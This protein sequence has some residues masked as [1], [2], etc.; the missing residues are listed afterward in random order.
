MSFVN[1]ISLVDP[2]RATFRA[3]VRSIAPL[4]RHFVRRRM[5]STPLE[6]FCASWLAQ[7]GCSGALGV[8]SGRQN[9][10]FPLFFVTL[11]RLFTISLEVDKTL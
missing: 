6:R 11:T 10:V 3:W 9:R 1:A 4:V 5:R 8:D 2:P 7:L